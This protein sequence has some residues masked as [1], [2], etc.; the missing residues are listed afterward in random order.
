M[1]FPRERIKELYD[2]VNGEYNK[3]E[4]LLMKEFGWTVQETYIATEYLYR[5][6][7]NYN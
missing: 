7:E 6:K 3:L 1:A 2:K 4:P 5:P